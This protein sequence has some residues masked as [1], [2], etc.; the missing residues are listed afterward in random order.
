MSAQKL[1]LD[2]VYENE[3][4]F[5]DRVY[6][7]QPI[8]GGQV[9]EY[10]WG[11]AL[12]RARRMATYLQ[13]QGLEP[14]DR[15]GIISKN[16][17]HF[18][19]TELAIWM[20]GY[21]T[22]ALYPTINAETVDYI[23]GHSGAKLMFVGK[24]DTWDEIQKGIP[25]DLP[26]VAMPLAPKTDF[27][28]WD[29]IVAN[30]DPLEGKPARAPDDLGILIYT[31]GSTG[32]P[33][34]VMHGFGQMSEAAEG[35]VKA[36][37]ITKEDRCLS[38]LPLAHVFER[39]YIE[40]ASFVAGTHIF[41]AEALTTFVADL[42][43]CRPTVFISVPRLWLKFQLGVFKKQPEKKLEFLMKI[44]ILGGIIKKKVLTGLGLDQVRLAG[45]GSAPIPAEL[46]AWYRR[47]GLNLIEGYAMSEDFAYSHL[48]RDGF[49]EPGY[50]GIPYDGVEVKISDEGE[51]LIKSPGCMQGYFEAPE[52]TAES[53][54]EDGFFK[55]GDRGERKP[56][57]MLKI[58][59]RTKELFKTS[60]GK[61]V[62]PAPI[63][64]LINVDNAV[65]SSMVTGSGQP[66]PC[67]LVVLNED[68]RSQSSDQATR[69]RLSAEFERLLGEVNGK[70]E[71]H[72]H[73]Q[74]IAV[75]S[76]EWTIESG[77]LTP[78]MK[79][80]RS[81]VEDAYKGAIEGWYGAKSK[82]VWA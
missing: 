78:T 13:A 79:I 49:S 1:L 35:I 66:Q 82:V 24:L 80:R 44:P 62:A 64:N 25:D 76:E 19:M 11:Q 73:L 23:I 14:G 37:E 68:L 34:G 8:G 4:K 2:Y 40:T 43:R 28:T 46:I 39:A 71:H 52:K 20:A 32:Q 48:S 50:V 51:I 47:L 70:V 72:E 22:V 29:H 12:D 5:A 3:T 36:L 57:G 61:Y 6:M 53:F 74:F 26:C 18:I 69:D 7:T 27:T 38:Y 33:K 15:V 81:A 45:S 67:A 58:T 21:V 77:M 16:C 30:N 41:F 75:I 10:T 63:E 60:K 54:T 9:K 56:N 31:S 59:G 17:A 42:N 55:T 65:E